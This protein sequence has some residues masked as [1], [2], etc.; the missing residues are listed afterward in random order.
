MQQEED[1][2]SHLF[3]ISSLIDQEEL[4]LRLFRTDVRAV[5][6]KRKGNLVEML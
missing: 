5:A 3:P 1:W 2:N 4:K 6:Q